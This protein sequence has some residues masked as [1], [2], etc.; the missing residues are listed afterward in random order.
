M[1]KNSARPIVSFFHR[2][3]SRKP[4][5][6]YSVVILGV[7]MAGSHSY[8]QI[9]PFRPPIGPIRPDPGAGRAKFQNI[10]SGPSAGHICGQ[11]RQNE[12]QCWGK[13]SHGQL[14]DGQTKD[15]AKPSSKVQGLGNVSLIVAGSEHTCALM[16]DASVK[17][18]GRGTEGQLGNGQSRD[19]LSPVTVPGIRAKSIAAGEF[20]TCAVLQAGNVKCWGAMN[21]GQLG[22]GQTSRIDFPKE[23]RNQP[24]DVIGVSGAVSVTSGASFSCALLTTGRVKCWGRNNALQLG[25]QTPEV[26][27]GTAVEANISAVRALSSG[28]YF[29]CAVVQTGQMVCWGNGGSGE[30]GNGGTASMGPNLVAP[31]SSITNPREF[32]TAGYSSCAISTPPAAPQV[33]GNGEVVQCW[34]S[35]SFGQLG[36]GTRQT[37]VWGYGSKTPVEVLDAGAPSKLAAGATFV[38]ALYGSS[39]IAND[40]FANTVQCWG[41]NMNGQLGTGKFANAYSPVE[42]EG[43]DSSGTM[44]I[45][46]S[47][48]CSLS[49]GEIR[50][51]GSGETMFPPDRS[52]KD[53][54]LP[55]AWA[56]PGA[57]SLSIGFN[58]S[59][60][61]LTNGTVKCWGKNNVGQIGNP[62]A[63][64]PNTPTA[65]SGLTDIRQISCGM[66]HCCSR[67][68]TGQIKCWGDGRYGATG[69]GN[70][71][72]A[73]VP[74]PVPVTGATDVHSGST[75][76][77]AVT[78][79]GGVQCWGFSG[80]P[81]GQ[82]VD[83]RDLRPYSIPNVQ[84]AVE[85]AVAHLKACARTRSGTVSCWSIPFIRNRAA[86]SEYY[87]PNV[88]VEAVPN[89]NGVVSIVAGSSHFCA[90]LNGGSVRCWGKSIDGYGNLEVP[91]D[92]IPVEVSNLTGVQ[93]IFGGSSITCA[94]LPGG[95]K[96]WGYGQSR[97]LGSQ[98]LANALTPVGVMAR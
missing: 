47:H 21:D 56:F 28:S 68:A 88:Q 29:S 83:P 92:K 65:V 53:R 51:W 77:C 41:S 19:S 4:F 66:D 72:T 42:M 6:V 20:H 98:I 22:N 91:E 39:I 57:S 30:L 60:V 54:I 14:G 49:G 90:L 46:W 8:S 80:I 73:T 10:W 55:D 62:S 52:T 35:N 15:L 23:A 89:L 40:A 38:C 2:I 78:A 67:S 27:T 64:D 75:S 11:T 12:I 87:P 97:M 95:V 74:S 34:G 31:V 70:Q 18:W 25:T 82:A 37:N 33:R 79:G 16:D 36:N 93:N 50:C 59:C 7:F 58:H 9:R 48:A 86:G 5:A 94:Y 13:N 85:T 3:V 84:G 1:Q 76:S 17:C 63:S 69:N 61:L 24:V 26:K 81:D 96:C 45:G 44:S 43:L 71:N 32:I